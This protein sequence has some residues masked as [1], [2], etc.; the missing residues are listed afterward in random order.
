MKLKEILG[1]L[2][3]A[4]FFTCMV[5]AMQ[6]IDNENAFVRQFKIRLTNCLKQNWHSDINESPRCDSYK[7]FKTFLNVERY[8]SIDM[9]FYVRKAF[10]RFRSSSHKLSIEIGRHHNIN[11]ADRLCLFCLNQFNIVTIED[12]YHAFFICPKFNT[13]R[14]KYLTPWYR[15]GDSRTVFQTQARDKTATYQETMYVCKRN[16]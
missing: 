3:F 7:E 4:F 9:P 2:T 1:H 15:Q 10:A 6:E 13:Q 5:L 12:Y 16:P 14:E 8:L 11:R